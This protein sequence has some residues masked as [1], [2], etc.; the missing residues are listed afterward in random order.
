MRFTGFDRSFNRKFNFVFYGAIL[1]QLATV[2]LIGFGGIYLF[3]HPEAI[4]SFF[5]KIVSGFK[6]AQ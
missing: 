1:I 2:A 5:G 3:N 4:G 6:S